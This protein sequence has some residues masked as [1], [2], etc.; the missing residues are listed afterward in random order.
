MGSSPKD[1][2]KET[3]ESPQHLISLSRILMG[4]YEVTLM[5]MIFSLMM[6]R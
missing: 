1:K 5:N 6:F 4:A 2:M 3:D